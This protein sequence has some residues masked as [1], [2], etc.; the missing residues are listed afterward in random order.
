MRSIFMLVV[1]GVVLVG[2]GILHVSYNKETGSATINIDKAK[3]KER[4]N[5]VIDEAKAFEGDSSTAAKK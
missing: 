1:L 3:A 5:Q 2:A 4:L